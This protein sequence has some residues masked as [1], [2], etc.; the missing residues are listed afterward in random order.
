VKQTI[1]D[2]DIVVVRWEC[3]F[4]DIGHR[5]KDPRAFAPQRSCVFDCQ[6]RNVE[7]VHCCPFLRKK[8]GVLAFAATGVQ[9]S[10]SFEAFHSGGQLLNQ[11]PRFRTPATFT[12]S[13]AV[14]VSSVAHNSFASANIAR[15][16]FRYLNRPV[17]LK[18]IASA[19]LI[20]P[21]TSFS[22]EA[23]LMLRNS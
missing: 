20:I 19:L 23:S 13:V 1:R 10:E 6:R 18:S 7:R 14:I 5:P 12:L 4:S 9:D 2:N 22:T 17:Q 16:A 21:S 8:H 15:I 3:D 11:A